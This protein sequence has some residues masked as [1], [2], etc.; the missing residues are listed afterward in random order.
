MTGHRCRASVGDGS[1]EGAGM[2]DPILVVNVDP[3]SAKIVKV[4]RDTGAL[5]LGEANWLATFVP[6]PGARQGGRPGRKP[7]RAL[8]AQPPTPTSHV[9]RLPPYLLFVTALGALLL[10]AGALVAPQVTGLV[11]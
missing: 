2:R 6:V 1:R 11:Q 8:P 3:N 10:S 5:P 4:Q 9:P 7:A